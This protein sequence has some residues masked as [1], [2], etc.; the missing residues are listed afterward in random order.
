MDVKTSKKSIGKRLNAVRKELNLSLDKAASY[1][2]K[3]ARTITAY[4]TGQNCVSLEYL[5]ALYTHYKININYI[6]TGEG[7]MFITKD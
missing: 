3:E 5:H 1:I 7:E 4:E 6:L 2:K